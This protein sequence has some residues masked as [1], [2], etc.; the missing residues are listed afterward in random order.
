MHPLRLD[1]VLKQ[2]TGQTGNKVEVDAAIKAREKT[3]LP[4]YQQVA[5]Q[6][7]DMHDTPA[8]MYA[9]GVLSGIVPWKE[10]RRFFAARLRR[11]L[12]EEAL[13]RHVASTDVS[14][15]RDDAINLV[16]SWHT[17]GNS[18]SYLQVDASPQAVAGQSF[19]FWAD[20]RSS[21]SNGTTA[22]AGGMNGSI[23]EFN[24]DTMYASQLEADNAFLAWAESAAGR[25]LIA[26]ELKGLR[27]RAASRLLKDML[28]TGEGKE[29]LLKGLQDVLQTDSALATQ[30][31]AML[32]QSSR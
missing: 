23:H 4:V 28:A 5:R 19:S 32:Q 31:R 27:S 15:R 20:E 12:T 6:F 30:L 26:M 10:A 24:P 11:R 8:R 25:A 9:K 17:L 22:A 18:I 2:L 29:G 7:A 13:V 3:L 1:P 21:G 16:H 14:I